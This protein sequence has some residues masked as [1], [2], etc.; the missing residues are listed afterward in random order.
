M[1]KIISKVGINQAESLKYHNVG[2][3]VAAPYGQNPN[4]PFR[5]GYNLRFN[6]NSYSARCVY[7]TSVHR[8]PLCFALC[9]GKLP[10]RDENA[11][12]NN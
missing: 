6:D 12:E 4:M 7:I 9:Y 11:F 1:F 5:A 10:L 2:Q 8:A 3:S